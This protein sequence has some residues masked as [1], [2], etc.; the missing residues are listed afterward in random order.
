[1]LRS[2][3]GVAVATIAL[4]ACNDVMDPQNVL[5]SNASGGEQNQSGRQPT[6]E[7]ST[8]D[9]VDLNVTAVGPFRP[10][11]PINIRAVAKANLAAPNAEYDITLLDSDQLDVRA[12]STHRPLAGG[13]ATLV[14]G[15]ARQLESVI[16]FARPGYYRVL[17]RA[18]S[19]S[20]STGSRFD[21]GKRVLESSH[22]ILWILVDENGG[23]LTNGYD[24]TVATAERAPLHGAYG[25]FVAISGPSQQSS[26]IDVQSQLADDAVSLACF[27]ILIWTPTSPC[28]RVMFNWTSGVSLTLP[29]LSATGRVVALLRTEHSRS[30]VRCHRGPECVHKSTHLFATHLRKC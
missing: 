27:G 19:P 26:D 12:A 6:Q 3:I 7:F 4:S 17:V 8:I 25:P 22:R 28:P 9:L 29:L 13:A 5:Q 1:M 10:G 24:I 18:G 11:L 21:N 16:T 14:P 20:N 2:L 30:R 15:L 23:R